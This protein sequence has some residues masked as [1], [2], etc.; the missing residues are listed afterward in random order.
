MNET[1]FLLNYLGIHPDIDTEI[2]KLYYNYLFPRIN[3]C[4]TYE[5]NE[6]VSSKESLLALAKKNNLL[7]YGDIIIYNGK[8]CPIRYFYDG[9]LIKLE[10][11]DYFKV[12]INNVPIHYWQ[13]KGVC[14]D[15]AFVRNECIHNIRHDVLY[16]DLS[17]IYTTFLYNNQQFRIIYNCSKGKDGLDYK[18]YLFKSRGKWD[19][20]KKD[21]VFH[22]NKRVCKFYIPPPELDDNATLILNFNIINDRHGKFY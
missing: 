14:F 8:F 4:F 3:G 18:K 21:F 13:S 15:H 16:D 19:T 22:L 12:I 1:I 6:T 17:G 7:V 2:K 20:L 10:N 11:N 5:I 9:T